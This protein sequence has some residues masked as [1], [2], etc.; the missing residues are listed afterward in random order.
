MLGVHDSFWHHHVHTANHVHGQ[1]GE[2]AHGQKL[3]IGKHAS[4]NTGKPRHGELEFSDSYTKFLNTHVISIYKKTNFQRHNCIATGQREVLSLV[5]ALRLS[6]MCQRWVIIID[7]III[8]VLIVLG[9][10]HTWSRGNI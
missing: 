3:N 6:N 5:T 8:I 10:H 7:G 9:D 1:T 2:H 4:V